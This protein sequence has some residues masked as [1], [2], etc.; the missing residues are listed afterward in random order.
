MLLLGIAIAIWRGA[1]LKGSLNGWEGLGI[2]LH[3]VAREAIALGFKGRGGIIVVFL[4]FD[5]FNQ[6]FA[7]C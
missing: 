1:A 4:F 3:E 7:P 6:V 2:R 5:R